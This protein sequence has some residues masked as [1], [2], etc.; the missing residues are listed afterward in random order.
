MGR[1]QNQD[2]D[3][4]LAAIGFDEHS[5]AILATAANL[6]KRMQ[7]RLRLVH[8]VEPWVG[9]MHAK[10]FGEN[11]PLWNVA[12]A[13]E[14]NAVSLATDRLKE[15]ASSLDK[16]IDCEV[17]VFQGAPAEWLD[18]DSFANHARL[19]ICG[20]ARGKNPF[21]PKGLS[22]ALSLLHHGKIPIL[23]VDKDVH[24]LPEFSAT[25]KKKSLKIALAD[26]LSPESERGVDQAMHVAQDMG[27]SHMDHFHV[28]GLSKENIEASVTQA[29][30]AS[31]SPLGDSVSADDLHA[32]ISEKLRDR[33]KG[34]K[35]DAGFDSYS[36][37][38]LEG[39]VHDEI[40]RHLAE[41]KPDIVI[42]GKH[43]MFHKKP[44]IIGRVPFR[45]MVSLNIP[46]M[47]IPG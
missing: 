21:L 23:I 30:A 32:A 47:V 9:R 29:L 41:T 43:Q 13:V 46:L 20:V 8:V 19:I 11:S 45:V 34:R 42:F 39:N 38:I 18:A 4:I 10:P 17:R 24:E 28:S 35:R 26:D 16:D 25:A 44:F 40:A 12:Y 3:M 7:K 5:E 6:A 36:Q 31:H 27:C 22:T 33:L 1:A 15:L 14:Q 37:V 2:R